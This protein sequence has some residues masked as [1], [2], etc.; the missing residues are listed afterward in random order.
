MSLLVVSGGGLILGTVVAVGARHSRDMLER[1]LEAKARAMATSVANRLAASQRSV[2]RDAAA[3]A[4]TLGQVP[5]SRDAVISLLQALVRDNPDV[6]GAAAAF[7]RGMA[8]AAG[9]TCPYVYRRGGSLGVK[10]LTAVGYR[11]TTWDWYVLP[12]ELRHAAWSEPYFDEGGGEIVMAT[13]SVP[14]FAD[15]GRGRFRGVVTCDVSLAGFAEMLASLPLGEAG[16]GVVLSGDGTVVSHRVKQYVMNETI[17]SLAEERDDPNLDAIG[18]RMIRGESGFVPFRTITTRTPSF[19]AFAPIG[20]TGWSLGLV[21]PEEAVTSKVRALERTQIV[22][23][24]AGFGG[25]LLVVL[26]VARSIT[27]PLR[28]LDKATLALAGGTLDAPV[29]ELKGD[30][31]VAHLA[32]SF[33]RMQRDLKAHIERLQATTAAKE[34]IE[35]ELQIARTIQLSLLPKTFPPFPERGD[36]ELFA[37]LEPAR[38]V[39]GDLY[40]FFLLDDDHLCLVAGDVAGKGVPAALHMAVTRTLIKA[41]FRATSEPAD[42]LGRLNH[43]LAQ[44]NESATFVTI[45]CA[46]VDLA[47]GSCRYANGG[48]NRPFVVRRSGEVESVPPVAGYV[49]GGMEGPPFGS[50]EIRLSRGDTLLLYTDG[51]VECMDGAGRLFGDDRTREELARLHDLPCEGIVRGVREALRLFAGAAEQSDDITMLAFRLGEPRQERPAAG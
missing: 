41:L 50:G 39:G 43:E 25:L 38:E 27:G 31:E 16:Y 6:F 44:E 24:V 10:E 37:T 47:S 19:L 28:H 42:V 34:R 5:A 22:L 18:H 26:A 8:D 12:K 33:A 29:P 32:S 7:E 1:E 17:F 21:F 45:F 2:E 35:R 23:G 3:L 40:D 4:R 36:I 46:V 13:F 20:D 9:P 51:V 49:V 30:D 14:V 11:F 48:H 15:D